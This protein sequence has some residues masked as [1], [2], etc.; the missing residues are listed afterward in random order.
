M[1]KKQKLLKTGDTG[2]IDKMISCQDNEN[3]L[4]YQKKNGHKEE[5]NKEKLKKKKQKQKKP[6][7]FQHYRNFQ[8]QFYCLG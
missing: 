7:L 3:Q 4:R 6:H 5:D 8:I 2:K 1:L